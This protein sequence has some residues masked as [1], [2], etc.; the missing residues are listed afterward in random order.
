MKCLRWGYCCHH[1]AVSIVDDPEIGVTED[2]IDG[3]EGNGK[4]CKHLSG[5]TPGEYSCNIHEYSWY[6]E[7]PCFS[8]GQ[9][10]KNVS[11][12]CRTGRYMLTLSRG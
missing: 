1:M 10:E 8:H 6:P 3:N 4:A 11:D 12:E 2:N 7:T 9:I 5:D